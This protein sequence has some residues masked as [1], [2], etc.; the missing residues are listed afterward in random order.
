MGFFKALI[1]EDNSHFR[2][3]LR[4]ILSSQF[5]YMAIEEAE[6]GKDALQ[7]VDTILPDLVFMDINLPGESGLQLTRKIKTKHPE[8]VVIV[9]T[10]YDLPEYEEA[11]F[12]YGANFFM[13]KGLSQKEEMLALVESI[14]K[15]SGFS[16]NGCQGERP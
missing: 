1:V 9:L 8:I 16:L 7:K 12:Q 4:D 6:D 11:A 5:P 13:I 2:H 3:T 15:D 14:L 10:S